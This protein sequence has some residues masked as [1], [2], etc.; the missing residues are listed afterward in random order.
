[1]LNT[2]PFHIPRATHQIPYT[3]Q[4]KNYMP[5]TT[6]YKVYTIDIDIYIYTYTFYRY[7]VESSLCKLLCT[8]H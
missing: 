2:I 5:D 7:T 6:Y 4:K 3:I 8:V 1:M